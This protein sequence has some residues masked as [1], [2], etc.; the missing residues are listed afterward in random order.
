MKNIQLFLISILSC[1]LI[2][3]SCDE[4]K[5]NNLFLLLFAGA[6]NRVPVVSIAASASPIAENNG[7]STITASIPKAISKDV[8][9]ELGFSGTA[10]VGT[11]YTVSGSTLVIPAGDT[12]QSAPVVITGVLDGTFDGNRDIIVSITDVTNATPGTTPTIIITDVPLPVASL[13]ASASTITEDGGISTITASIPAES[14]SDVT[15][16]MGFSGTPTAPGDYT[17]TGSTTIVIPAGSTFGSTSVI[18]TGVDDRRFEGDEDVVV[19]I[20]GVTNATA[21]ATPTIRLIDAET[22][23]TQPLTVKSVSPASG[24]TGV[25]PLNTFRIYITFNRPTDGS[26]GTV[27]I[28]NIWQDPLL[29]ENGVNSDMTFNTQKNILTI[30]NT[31]GWY[32]GM[33]HEHII[34][35]GFKDADGTEMEVYDDPDYYFVT[36]THAVWVSTPSDGAINV[37]LSSVIRI[38]F[39][40]YLGT[41]KGTVTLDYNE[42]PGHGSGS[43]TFID[44]DNCTITFSDDVQGSNVIVTPTDELYIFTVYS[45]IRVSGF[46]DPYGNDV[47]DYV[48]AEYDFTT[49]DIN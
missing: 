35:T 11:D 2:F 42:T 12:T 31:L 14:V 36:H 33:L 43:I 46:K 28:H 29:F 49:V 22:L 17:V 44:S 16:V 7:I 48:D 45:N 18:I 26:F 19:S 32:S 23:A 8:T 38:H 27:A 47:A 25:V 20:T 5:D 34:V 37:D 6:A 30:R 40:G 1:V 13:A 3:S 10:A 9:V 21:G 15:V 39:Y 4:E 41:D 24:S